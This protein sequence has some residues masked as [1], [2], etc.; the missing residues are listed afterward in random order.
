M[1][2]STV[3]LE[4]EVWWVVLIHNLTMAVQGVDSFIGGWCYFSQ[5]YNNFDGIVSYTVILGS[6]GLIR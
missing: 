5:E 4:I 2:I 6:R 1:L 3:S